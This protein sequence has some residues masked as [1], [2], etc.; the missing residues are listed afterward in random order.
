MMLPNDVMERCR[1]VSQTWSDILTAMESRLEAHPE[2][3]PDLESLLE[4]LP[5][6]KDYQD[7]L[8]DQYCNSRTLGD[9]RFLTRVLDDPSLDDT[10]RAILT[11]W[12]DKPA[13]YAAF[14]ITGRKG[15]N[16]YEIEDLEHEKHSMLYSPGLQKLQNRRESRAA[17]YVALL[18]DNG[19]CLQTA[20]MFHYN[21]LE[22]KDFDFLGFVV[23]APLYA[24]SGLDGLLKAHPKLFF[25]LFML[26]EVPEPAYRSTPLVA[27]IA[28]IGP[29][30]HHFEEPYWE[31]L[32]SGEARQYIFE[33]ASPEMVQM[34]GEQ[35]F[36]AEPPPFNVRLFDCAG[37][38]YLLTHTAESFRT[39]AAMMGYP[40]LVAE[41]RPSIVLMFFLEDLGYRLPWAPFTLLGDGDMD[42][43]TRRERDRQEEEMERMNAFMEEYVDD[44]NEGRSTNMTKLARRHGLTYNEATQLVEHLNKTLERHLWSVPAEEEEYQVGGRWPVPPPS[45]LRNF[46]DSL[47]SSRLFF[48][49]DEK[50]SDDR[51]NA[52]TQGV[53]KEKVEMGGVAEVIED[54]FME[55]FEWDES[56]YSMLNLLLWIVLNKKG[57]SVVVRSIVVE[58]FKLFPYL[59][60]EYDFDSFVEFFSNAVI[61]AG[62]ATSLLRVKER[63]RGEA[64]RRALFGVQ[65]SDLLC[66]LV[67]PIPHSV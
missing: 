34:W 2:F 55:V 26:S 43:E 53:W 47:L 28:A 63:P 21:R 66:Y 11:E 5:E 41:H 61:K 37:R 25:L 32:T 50:E 59:S 54:L 67:T 42:E 35:P 27:H 45:M 46:G 56:G 36:F 18:V 49:L 24:A 60:R 8:G 57:E 39:F 7:N 4:R 22:K 51:F 44:L 12:V 40:G 14:T 52:E 17:T 33:K 13:F 23:D 1:L 16:L 30:S 3:E 29:V 6:R 15:D 38:W 31:I 9:A 58:A 10:V 20:S 62:I 48:V 19:L 64:R 65:A